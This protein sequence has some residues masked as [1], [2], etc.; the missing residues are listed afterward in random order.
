[1]KLTKPIII[2][3]AGGS[4]SG[5]T[6]IADI[7]RQ[8]FSETNSVII[9]R[10]DDYY[11][12]Q[13]DLTMEERAKTNYDHPNAFDFDL[14]SENLN[15]LIHLKQIC[16]PTY[17]YTVHNRSKVIEEVKPA[18]VIILEGL[19][20]L[21]N[22]N[23]REIEDIKVF[24]DTP[25]DVRFI[26]RLNRDVTERKRTVESITTQY[27]NTVKPMH[28]QFIEPTKQYADVII[29]RGMTNTVGIDLL[30]TKIISILNEKML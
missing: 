28:D 13:S 10:E 16:K 27:L 25:A 23:I 22:P 1:M 26:R 8:N 19:F 4:C 29:P 12:D 20:A 7:L 9:I 5:K 17:D 21:Y 3:I 15:D 14:M 2:G 11:K 18:D 30:N 6:S 24:V